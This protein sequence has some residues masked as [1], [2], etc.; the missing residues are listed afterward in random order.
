MY[1][2]TIGKVAI[3]D[4]ECATNQACCA[5]IHVPS[6]NKK[7]LLYYL[8]AMKEYFI[9]KGEDGAQPNI[10][11]EKI[12]ATPFPVPPLDEQASIVEKI[13]I[14]LP[15]REQIGETISSI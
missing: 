11:K 6:I 2:A 3:A 15:L 4:F 8:L 10:S 9:G 7:F 1:G 5:C 13:E 14:L 12:V